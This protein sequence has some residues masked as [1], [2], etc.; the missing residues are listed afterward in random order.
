[1]TSGLH[2]KRFRSKINTEKTLLLT[3][4]G[5]CVWLRE[6]I[7]DIRIKIQ[8][9]SGNTPHNIDRKRREYVEER[10]PNDI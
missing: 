10:W 8:N 1:M 2:A 3:W 9:M 5:A 7:S 4:L 6:G